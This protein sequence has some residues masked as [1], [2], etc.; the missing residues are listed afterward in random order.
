MLVPQL[1]SNIKL[2]RM[3]FALRAHRLAK[4]T[5]PFWV[6][7]L[8]Q[9]ILQK[10]ICSQ[11]CRFLR[12]HF[13]SRAL[14]CR[15]ESGKF[16]VRF[17]RHDLA[18]QNCRG[19]ALFC[20]NP[21]NWT[22]HPPFFSS[23]FDNVGVRSGTYSACGSWTGTCFVGC[24]FAGNVYSQEPIGCSVAG[25]G[26]STGKD[27]LEFTFSESRTSCRP[28]TVWAASGTLAAVFWKE[29][30]WWKSLKLHNW[31]HF[32]VMS[33]WLQLKHITICSCMWMQ[34]MYPAPLAG[35]PGHV[36]AFKSNLPHTLS[37]EMQ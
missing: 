33:C 25:L 18:E 34:K 10:R 27:V 35:Q 11:K 30:R 8:L 15:V 29:S 7:A 12:F 24:R 23:T 20:G 13:C 6:F 1:Q 2:S 19:R 14:S 22:A 21:F 37:N 32:Q 5:R 16:R 4:K 26:P 31:K 17:L 3:Y 28:F 36:Y 9:V